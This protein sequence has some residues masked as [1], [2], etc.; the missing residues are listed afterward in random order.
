MRK[1]L[2]FIIFYFLLPLF[3]LGSLYLITFRKNSVNVINTKTEVQISSKKLTSSFLENEDKA[4]SQYV[5]KIVEIEGI[6]KNITFFNNRYTVLLHGE[7]NYSCVMCDMQ[8][9]QYNQIEKL[10]V[11]QSITLKGVCKGFLMDAIVLNCII[12]KPYNN[13]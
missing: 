9:D 4:N 3:I 13:E 7:T 5:E 12:L 8:P 10:H 1:K 6:V 11:G 2:K